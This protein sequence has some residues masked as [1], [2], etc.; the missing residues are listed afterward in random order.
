MGV[1]KPMHFA[2]SRKKNFSYEEDEIGDSAIRTD[3]Q[4]EVI[5][6]IGRTFDRRVGED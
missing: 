5:S 6:G 2:K 4:P 3:S 1:P